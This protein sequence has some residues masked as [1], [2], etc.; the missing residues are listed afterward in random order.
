MVGAIRLNIAF[1]VPL[2]S[3]ACRP[4]RLCALPALAA[5]SLMAATYTWDGGGSDSNWLTG[6]NWAGNVAP[7]KGSSTHIFEFGGNTRLTNNANSGDWAVGTLRFAS[8]AG[9]FNLT[10][11][12][13][14]IGAGGVTNNSGNAQV[15]ANQ[16]KLGANQ[17]WNA[18]NGA[19]TFNGY[20]GGAG[21]ALTLKGANA[22]TFNDQLNGTGT[23]TISGSGNRTFNG[24]TSATTLNAGGTGTS[25]YNAQVNTTTVNVTSGTHLF[26]STVNVSNLYISG[27]TTTLGGSAAKNIEH[28]VVNGG[29]LIM[30]RTGGG[31]AIN[32]SL[33]VNDGGTVVFENDHQV[34]AWT[35]VT[36]NE[37]STLYLGDTTQ[38]FANLV[39]TGD[40]VID[41]GTGG[42]Q[43]NITYGGIDIS[44]D[45]TLTIVNWN[46]ANGDVF[47]GANPGAPVVN[48][49][50]A[51]NEGNVYATGTWGGG[52]VQP[53][54]PVPEP[55]T[56][57]FMMLGAGVGFFM[58]RRR[59]PARARAGVRG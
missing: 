6:G 32:G 33:V 52:L 58:W 51:D 4:L 30:A 17:D 24:Y 39:I 20:V 29:T 35:S 48:V 10:G 55:A 31:D 57:G 59:K 54:S 50:Y 19:L 16:V 13:L 41:F 53:G 14:T 27:G 11:G 36:L 25:N 45:I 37:G 12:E 7:P 5:T 9:A 26:N 38:T 22:I 47:A 23:L 34:P 21:K 44:D 40:S 3:S 56:Y 1:A 18:A 28:T 2:L 43:L 46:A 15:I 8:N 49:Q 42:S